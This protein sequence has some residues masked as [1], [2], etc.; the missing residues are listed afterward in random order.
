MILLAGVVCPILFESLED[1][2]RLEITV[3]FPMPVDTG[4]VEG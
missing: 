3:S 1:V 4:V 2:V